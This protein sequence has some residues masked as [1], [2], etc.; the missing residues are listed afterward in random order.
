[1]REHEHPDQR[2][3]ESGGDADEDGPPSPE[4]LQLA[5]VVHGASTLCRIDDGCTIQASFCMR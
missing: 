2:D 4:D 5:D 1:L 3:D